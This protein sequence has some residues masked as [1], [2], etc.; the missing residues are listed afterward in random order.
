M[1]IC[2]HVHVPAAASWVVTSAPVSGLPAIADT[3]AYFL[4]SRTLGLSIDYRIIFIIIVIIIVMLMIMIIVCVNV[5]TTIT[6]F[7]I[8]IIVIILIMII[9]IIIIIMVII[10][11]RRS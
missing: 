5:I 1:C 9:I 7:S 6:I 3:L 4:V 8:I 10:I 11:I 2:I